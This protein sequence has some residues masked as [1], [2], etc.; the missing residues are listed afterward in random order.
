MSHEN[1][2][3][4]KNS[5]FKTYLLDFIGYVTRHSCVTF[6]ISREAVL[7]SLKASISI[8]F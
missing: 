7:Q 6:L 2:F 8:L 1:I 4:G 5:S 3:K